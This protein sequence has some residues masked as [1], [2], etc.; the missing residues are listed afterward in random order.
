SLLRQRKAASKTASHFSQSVGLELAITVRKLSTF[1]I[2]GLLKTN[3]SAAG[4]GDPAREQD[5]PMN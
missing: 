5:G 3:I 4:S 1:T 2:A